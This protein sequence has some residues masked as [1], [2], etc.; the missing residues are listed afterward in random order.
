MTTSGNGKSLAL[1]ILVVVLLLFA[2]RSVFYILPFGVV[3]GLAH[4]LR[5]AGH[6]MWRFPG[7]FPLA[8]LPLAFLLLW[9]FV[10]VWVY[11]DAESRGMS[12]LL[13]ALLV[14]VGNVIGLIIFLIVRNEP[15]GR[16]KAPPA[17][18]CPACGN[19]VGAGFA[20][21]PN[22]G[23]SLKPVCSGCRRPV[24][25]SWKVCPDCG[26]GLGEGKTEQK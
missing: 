5:D 24:D 21:C 15:G 17:E 22:C 26:T 12:G 25:R 1:V 4:S 13:W 23:A 7:F 20:Y 11:R 16:L 9:V 19:P 14:F 8:F 6:S 18:K 3:P 2:F 10:I